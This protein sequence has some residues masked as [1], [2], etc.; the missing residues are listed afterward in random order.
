MRNPYKNLGYNPE[1]KE[2]VDWCRQ[3]TRERAFD[4]EDYDDQ[5]R[6]NPVY[7]TTPPSSSS[8]LSGTEKEGDLAADTSYL[9][10]VVNNSG[11]LQWQRVA[12]STF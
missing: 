11:T 1:I 9:Y 3:A 10:I 4:L 8:D 6:T 5:I 7:F 2:I 12:T